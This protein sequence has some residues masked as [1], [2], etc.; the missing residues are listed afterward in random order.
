MEGLLGV[1]TGWGVFCGGI[2]GVGNGWGLFCGGMLGVRAGRGLFCAF[3]DVESCL[4][5]GKVLFSGLIHCFTF[6]RGVKVCFLLNG[7]VRCD[8]LPDGLI[9]RVLVVG[10][11]FCITLC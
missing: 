9:L 8:F 11:F 2:L 4:D 1:G 10:C 7:D 3:V 6:G 5:R